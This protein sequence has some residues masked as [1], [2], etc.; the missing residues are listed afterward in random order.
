MRI[1][2]LIV[3][4]TL[5]AILLVGCNTPGG[6]TTE[7]NAALVSWTECLKREAINLDDGFSDPLA[8]GTAVAG[9]CSAEQQRSDDTMT[10]GQGL[11]YQN[12]FREGSYRNA[13]QLAVEAVLL[14][15]KQIR[16]G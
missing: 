8:I 16:G 7:Q 3:V 12:A 9:A 14:H 11:A 13:L 15:R 2:V 5:A 1:L 4:V 6:L 10:A